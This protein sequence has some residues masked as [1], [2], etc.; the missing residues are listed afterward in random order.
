MDRIFMNIFGY[1]IEEVKAEVKIQGRRADYV[2][3]VN[4][5]DV[6]VVEV[7]KAGVPLKKEHIFQA[8]SYAAYSGIKYALLTNLSEFILF[9]VQAK[10]VVE[11][12]AIFSIDL[13]NGLDIKDIK[14]LTLISRYGMTKSE[15]LE[16]LS[17]QVIASSPSSMSRIL[18]NI[19]VIDKI[20]EIIKREQNC[21]VSQ[22]QIQ[23]TIELLLGI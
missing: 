2:L 23:E 12:N 7:K 17:D 16:S 21:D 8:S 22:E 10:D 19:E 3:A 9:K 20:K 1:E 15:L 11:T 13:L 5:R 14:N 6:M 18:L 4:D